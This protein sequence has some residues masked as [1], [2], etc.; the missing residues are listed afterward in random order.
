MAEKGDGVC[1]DEHRS[2]TGR[3]GGHHG[4][5]NRLWARQRENRKQAGARATM[6][7]DRAEGGRARQGG[8]RR[9]GA[10][11]PVEG[12][13]EQERGAEELRPRTRHG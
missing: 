3:E 10:R 8:E 7:G 12:A 2:V 6:A 9:E 1:R 4:R 13:A 5:G 11:A